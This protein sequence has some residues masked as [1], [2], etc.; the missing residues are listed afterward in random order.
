MGSG[1]IESAHRYIIQQRLKKS[2]AWWKS[3]NAADMLALR[4]MRGNQQWK[5]YWRNTAEAA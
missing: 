4:V 3:D 5:H 1:E 2:G